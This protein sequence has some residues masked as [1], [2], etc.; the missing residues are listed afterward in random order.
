[1]KT[2]FI[3][4]IFIILSTCKPDS[5]NQNIETVLLSLRLARLLS[6]DVII[7]GLVQGP[8]LIKNA[9]VEIVEVPKSGSCVNENG[10]A[11][12]A[13]IGK[14]KSDSTGNY[15]VTYKRANGNVCVLVTPDGSS[16]IEVFNPTGAI[17][18]DTAWV[19][20]NSMMAVLSEPSSRSFTA[21]RKTVNVTP[22]TRMASR[23]FFA[24]NGMSSS[25][26]R[27]VTK[28][29]LRVNA[30][31]QNS[32][33]RGKDGANKVEFGKNNVTTLLDKAYEDVENAFFPKAAAGFSLLGADPSS[34][35][36][37][38]RLGAINN[39]ADKLGGGAA[40]GN[41]GSAD[42]EKVVNFMEED[43]SDG[44]FDGKKIDPTT[45]RRTPMNAEDLG[46]VVTNVASADDFMKD[47]FKKAVQEYDSQDPSIISTTDDLQFCDSDT[48]DAACQLAT[49]PGSPA[50]LYVFDGDGELVDNGGIGDFGPVGFGVGGTSS[51]RLFIFVNAGGTNLTLKTPMTI[52]DSRFVILEQ[53]DSIVVPGDASYLL[54]QFTPTS[55]SSFSAPLSFTHSDTINSP[56]TM[57]QTASGVDVSSNIQLWWEFD[58][59][60]DDSTANGRNGTL[61]GPPILTEDYYGNANSAYS[62]NSLV[63]SFITYATPTFPPSSGTA[64]S[65]SAL[66][67]PT[68]LSQV[69]TNGNF[70]LSRSSDF[71]LN[72]FRNNNQDNIRFLM[73]TSNGPNSIVFPIDS[74]D[75]IDSWNLITGTYN[76]SQMILYINGIEV[77]QINH[78]G[79]ILNNVN[80]RVGCSSSG[81]SCFD[82]DIDDVRVYNRTLT[83]AQV[84]ALYN[85]D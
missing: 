75:F 4:L 37:A 76:G 62:F 59:D 44:R 41:I 69:N 27:S 51:T 38:L 50:E 31:S 82:G 71:M 70:I 19:G 68:K 58:G 49:I 30:N 7:S 25:N 34:K 35:Q 10:E 48:I 63:P 78:T 53:P 65:F 42:L 36:Y 79:N 81:S 32:N 74:A 1:M 84:L 3:L 52:S 5:K 14:G 15:T 23:R 21:Q 45:N 55:I 56:F 85:Q 66:V 47:E 77:S 43:F 83:P 16:K 13:V 61:N 33:L 28:V 57:T 12:G 29:F 17:K 6:E 11:I 18:R 73:T 8:G 54:I 46:G 2:F 80:F 64:G 22:F 26:L 40:D 24:L 9:K 60:G 20:R 72:F 67:A 39:L